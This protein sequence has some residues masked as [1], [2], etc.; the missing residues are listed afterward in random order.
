MDAT[1]REFIKSTYQSLTGSV[2]GSFTDAWR[3]DGLGLL[4]ISILIVL[5]IYIFINSR[6]ETCGFENPPL[7][8]QQPLAKAQQYTGISDLPEAPQNNLADVNSLPYQDPAMAKSSTEMLRQLKQDMDGFSTFE[9]EKM[10]DVSD[11]SVKLPITQFKGDYQRV[12]DEL[13]VVNRTPGVQPS[14]SV[15]KINEMAANLRFLQR[16]YRTYANNELVPQ[17][18]TP[19]TQVGANETV[20]GFFVAKGNG[21]VCARSTE[22][23][24]GNCNMT[25]N[26][27]VCSDPQNP[28]AITG[29]SYTSSGDHNSVPSICYGTAGQTPNPNLGRPSPGNGLRLYTKAECETNLGG[30]WESNGVCHERRNIDGSFPPLS[31]S[32]SVEC[33]NM[34]PASGT[35][36]TAVSGSSITTAIGTNTGASSTGEILKTQDDFPIVNGVRTPNPLLSCPSNHVAVAQYYGNN[37]DAR[38]NLACYPSGTTQ[39]SSVFQN[40]SIG[41]LIIAPNYSEVNLMDATGNIVDTINNSNG[42]TSPDPQFQG[43]IRKYYSSGIKFSSIKFTMPPAPPPAPSSPGE[44]LKTQDDFTIVNG[45]ITPDPL[46]SCPINYANIFQQL[47]GNINSPSSD[48]RFNLACY[49]NGTTQVNSVFQNDSMGIGIMAPKDSE[50]KLIDS[51]GNIVA[52][53][54]NSNTN[55]NSHPQFEGK[56]HK[57]YSPA[58]KFSSIKFT[59]P[60]TAS[61]PSTASAPSTTA[62]PITDPSA[63]YNSYMSWMNSSSSGPGTTTTV[64]TVSP[65]TSTTMGSNVGSNVTPVMTDTPTHTGDPNYARITRTQ[66]DLLVQKI[67]VEITRL[68]ASGTTDPIVRARVNIFLRIK[69]SL[70]DI[71]AA[72]DAGTMKPEDI[73]ILVKDYN[74]FLPAI[75]STNTGIAGLLSESGYPTLASLFNAFSQGDITNSEINNHLLH[76]YAR[77]LINGLS[78]KFDISYTS[79][80]EVEARKAEAI[81]AAYDSGDTAADIGMNMKMYTGHPRTMHGSRGAFDSHVRQM[82]LN[83]FER[84]SQGYSRPSGTASTGGSGGFDWKGRAEKI[85]DNVKRAGMDPYDY[86]MDPDVYANAINTDFSWRGYTK[87]VC[88]RLSTNAEQG[89]AEKMGCPPASWIGW[90]S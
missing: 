42:D 51:T 12:K 1:V 31:G 50:V 19:M 77:A 72:L 83:G 30:V 56:I 2:K 10:P 87:M 82:D 67:A 79:A 4:S 61:T 58:I 38:F 21:E 88:S 48:L 84:D 71:Q 55:T 68:Q 66:L 34:N 81:K 57:Y 86:G 40:D 74:N 7:S 52:T 62:T 78:Y 32:R 76:S 8:A 43:R 18:Q 26:P 20:E 33:R 46:N 45:M 54:N 70:T 47:S 59:L 60:G 41:V 75:G 3:I 63:L 89:M 23:S 73:P 64:D 9:L 39:A 65:S 15:Q 25:L 16:T 49:P 29:G 69:Q 14:L 53:L 37:T 27:H 22:C 80:N 85:F 44:I 35:A 28:S 90:R 5:G 6:C 13:M 11:P 24:S 36:S 17:P